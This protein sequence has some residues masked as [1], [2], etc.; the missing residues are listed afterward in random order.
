MRSLEAAVRYWQALAEGYRVKWQ[1]NPLDPTDR[2]FPSFHWTMIK[3]GVPFWT[4]ECCYVPTLLLRG[5]SG[6]P[7][8]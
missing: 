7:N 5:P 1:N 4:V 2:Y 6:A 8:A 3:P